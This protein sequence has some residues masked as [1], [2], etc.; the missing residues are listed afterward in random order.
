MASVDKKDIQIGKFNTLSVVKILDFGCYLDGGTAGEILLPRRYVPTDVQLG[1]DINVFIYFDSEDRL[2]ATTDTPR[3]LV[4]QVAYLRVS[5]VG[6]PGAFL[7]W[8]LPKDLLVPRSQQRTPM[9]EGHSYVVYVY[10]DIATGRIAASSKFSRFV[11]NVMP[12]YAVGDKVSAIVTDITPL[13]YKVIIENQHTA[14]LYRNEVFTPLSV[15]QSIVAYV[16]KV[17]EDDLIDLSL[18]PLGYAKVADL[19]EAITSALA[20]SGGFLPV[21][22][23][24]DPEQIKTLFGCSKKSFKMTI[25][26]LMR[27]K[28]ILITPDGIKLIK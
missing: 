9:I 12:R 25:G 19:A 27:Q 7:D 16:K 1:D 24:S 5:Q 18:T 26:T 17:R 4:G 23:H 10:R 28:Q 3:A 8:G 13:G 6:S 21:G 15:G 11:D 14:I 22:D 2:V 20:Q